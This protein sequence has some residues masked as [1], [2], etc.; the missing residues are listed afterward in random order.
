MVNDM[1]KLKPNKFFHFPFLIRILSQS[2]MNG[3]WVDVKKCKIRF[4][5]QFWESQ[6]GSLNLSLGWM[7]RNMQVK[8]CIKSA[9]HEVQFVKSASMQ[10]AAAHVWGTAEDD[11]AA[12]GEQHAAAELQQQQCAEAAAAADFQQQQ[13]QHAPRAEPQ[14][15]QHASGAE[16]KHADAAGD[17]D[18]QEGSSGIL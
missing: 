16:L 10:G 9:T 7:R 2:L 4:Y 13:L 5:I 1:E 3:L 12:G 14:Q 18:D 11:A 8:L 6:M 17:Q 15:L